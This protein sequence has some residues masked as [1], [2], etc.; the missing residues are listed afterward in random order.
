MPITFLYK[1]KIKDAVSMTESEINVYN[2][3]GTSNLADDD[4][5]SAFRGDT[6]LINPNIGTT[7]ILFNFGSAVYMDSIA[8]VCNL[9]I[10]GTCWLTAGINPINIAETFGIPLNGLGTAHSYFGGQFQTDPPQPYQYWKLYMK[11]A[12][13]I[14]T[15]QINELFLGKRTTI[16]EMP[17]YPFINEIEENTVELI[18]ERGQR[19]SYSNYE[20][21]YWIL[22]FEGV[23]AA[24][25]S[26]LFNIY[27]YCRKNTQPFWFCLYPDTEPLNI[28]FVRFRDNAFLSSEE[29][30][31]VYDITIELEKNT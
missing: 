22:N 6:H 31:N 3:W 27:K 14:L 21:E 15:H 16:S 2:G 26:S 9:T 5:N 11:G 17:S 30:K 10:N 18:S 7:T 8:I 19:W 1:N 24:T 4:I 20:R 23:N 28:K 12:T 25:E 13:S 29:T